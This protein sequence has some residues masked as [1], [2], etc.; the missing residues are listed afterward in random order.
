MHVEPHLA[1]TQSSIA[2]KARTPA[3]KR[4]GITTICF[5]VIAVVAGI[6]LLPGGVMTRAIAAGTMPSQP[7]SIDGAAG[8]QQVSLSWGVSENATG[9]LVEQV[10]LAT[11]QVLQ[12]PTVVTETSSTIGSLAAG[13]WYRF[14]IIPVNGTLQ[15]TPSAS[16]E[17]RTIGFQGSYAHYYVLGDSYS[18]GEG[19]P[20]YSGVKGC[21]RSVNS[22]GNQ[23]GQGAPVPVIIACSGAVTDDI[24]KITQNAGLSGTQIQQLQR[25]P[26]ANSLITLTI[27][28][29]DANFAS[30]LEN[31]IFGLHACTSRRAAISQRIAA[32]EPRL[33]QVYREIRNAAPG[34]DI[35]VLG[36]PLLTAAPDVASCHNP[37]I[38]AG[39]SKSEMGMIR[40]LAGQLNKVIAQAAAQAGVV[41]AVSQV[42]QAFAGHEVCTKNQQAEWINEIT[43]ITNMIH[44]S[45]HPK[46]AGYIADAQ[47]VNAGRIALYQTG[48]VRLV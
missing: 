3:F 40:E 2:F 36:Y 16:I 42:E 39:L 32:L 18:S 30:E 21:Y 4:F 8:N 31:C 7:T 29:N 17:I 24:D 25:D 38:K 28:G 1:Q 12:L 10:D 46:T 23:L 41:S 26:L 22:Y 20:P 33:V 37:L 14:R 19:A 11:G 5:I 35:I 15:G 47:A 45:F 13:H 44:G 48:M 34:A 6:A 9:Y 43:G 27:G